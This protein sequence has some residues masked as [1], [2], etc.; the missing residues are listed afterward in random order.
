MHK[1]FRS[2]NKTK[3]ARAEIKLKSFEILI[4]LLRR[5]RGPLP[6]VATKFFD[7]VSYKTAAS[8]QFFNCLLKLFSQSERAFDLFHSAAKGTLGTYFLAVLLG[9]QFDCC[10]LRPQNLFAS[11]ILQVHHPTNK[12]NR[13]I[14][15]ILR[16]PK[17]NKSMSNIL[18]ANLFARLY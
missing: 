18:K 15:D 10:F 8:S 14:S 6:K 13:I 16:K 4:G 5:C 11:G 2:L 12:G 7:A 1:L 3:V 9:I 17:I